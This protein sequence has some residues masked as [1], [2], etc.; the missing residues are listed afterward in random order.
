MTCRDQPLPHMLRQYRDS[1]PLAATE[2]FNQCTAASQIAQHQ[3]SRAGTAAV[4]S[5]LA[6]SPLGAWQV[7]KPGEFGQCLAW[8]SGRRTPSRSAT[9]QSEV[10]TSSTCG[11]A[12]AP[13]PPAPPPPLLPPAMPAAPCPEGPGLGGSGPLAAAL[14]PAVSPSRAAAA[15]GGRAAAVLVASSAD[16][17]PELCF[18]PGPP[19]SHTAASACRRAARASWYRA[20]AAVRSPLW[21]ARSPSLLADSAAAR[22]TCAARCCV[23]DVLNFFKQRSTGGRR[24]RDQ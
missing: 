17:D 4:C 2:I 20:C 5:Q 3:H 16:P 15:A 13:I 7:R 11:T 21:Y 18:T 9:L 6:P 22:S 23:S 1:C 12:T 8:V 19:A 24:P 14:L 10:A